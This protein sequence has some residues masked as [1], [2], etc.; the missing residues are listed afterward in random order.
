MVR[1]DLLLTFLLFRMMGCGLSSST[2]KHLLA[3]LNSRPGTVARLM[4]ASLIFP[5]GSRPG[6]V[7]PPVDDCPDPESGGSVFGNLKG[8]GGLATCCCCCESIG[9]DAWLQFFWWG[10]I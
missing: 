3:G 4:S 2:E 5:V 7:S 9:I 8:L 6:D 10:A 1:N